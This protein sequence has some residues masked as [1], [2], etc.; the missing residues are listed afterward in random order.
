MISPLL[1]DIAVWIFLETLLELFIFTQ[2][3]NYCEYVGY[4]STLRKRGANDLFQIVNDSRDTI[5]NIV[6]V[7]KV[8]AVPV[9][10]TW[11]QQYKYKYVNLLFGPL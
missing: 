3:P 4:A 11:R 2:V 5:A 10:D 9:S 7:D 6:P 1:D 8:Q